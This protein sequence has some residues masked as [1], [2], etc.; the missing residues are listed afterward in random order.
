MNTIY[1]HRLPAARR[2]R[3]IRRSGEINLRIAPNCKA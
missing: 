1:K 2:E 3:F